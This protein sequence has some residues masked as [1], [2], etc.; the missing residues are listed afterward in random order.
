MCNTDRFHFEL[1]NVGRSGF[2]FGQD[3]NLSPCQLNCMKTFPELIDGRFEIVNSMLNVFF[4][5]A[6]FSFVVDIFRAFKREPR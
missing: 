1:C 6:F 4:K 2:K 3:R 5:R